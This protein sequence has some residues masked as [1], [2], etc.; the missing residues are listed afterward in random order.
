MGN[1]QTFEVVRSAPC[2]HVELSGSAR[3]GPLDRTVHRW[4]PSPQFSSDHKSHGRQPGSVNV[5]VG[6]KSRRLSVCV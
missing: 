6:T 2:L 3:A 1:P 5:D 4:S